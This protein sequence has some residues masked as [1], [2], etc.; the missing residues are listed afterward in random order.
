MFRVDFLLTFKDESW[1]NGKEQA[2]LPR[3]PRFRV[4][5]AYFG[6]PFLAFL[7]PV[8]MS[9]VFYK[10]RN[11]L[12]YYSFVFRNWTPSLATWG[13]GAGAGALLVRSDVLICDPY[14]NL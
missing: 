13:V 4:R 3:A 6:S 11:P 9:R 10:S 12:Q 7:L 1:I 5:T 2:L 14:P 8:K